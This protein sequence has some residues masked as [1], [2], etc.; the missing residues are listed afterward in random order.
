MTIHS[1]VDYPTHTILMREREREREREVLCGI[2]DIS[3]PCPKISWFRQ[4]RKAQN[5]VRCY[6]F[7]KRSRR[8]KI[9]FSETVLHNYWKPCGT[10]APKHISLMGEERL[11][12]KHCTRTDIGKHPTELFIKYLV[13]AVFNFKDGPRINFIISFKPSLWCNFLEYLE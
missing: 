9:N 2:I 8:G 11:D 12:Q 10:Q 13:F 1:I 7:L 5:V 3:H 6:K 4:D